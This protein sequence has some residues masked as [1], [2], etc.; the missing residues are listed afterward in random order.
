MRSGVRGCS[1][2]PLDPEMHSDFMIRCDLVE[3][4]YRAEKELMK[5]T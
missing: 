5:K 2:S 4:L 1:Q 3:E